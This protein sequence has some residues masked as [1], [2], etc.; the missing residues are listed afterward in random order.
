MKKIFLFFIVYFVNCTAAFACNTNTYYCIDGRLGLGIYYGNLGSYEAWA[1]SIG[2]YGAFNF[3]YY[4]KWFYTSFDI[5]IGFANTAITYNTNNIIH[6]RHE[7]NYSILG[8]FKVGTTLGFL[9]EPTFIYFSL[10]AELYRVGLTGIIN[11]TFSFHGERGAFFNTFVSLGIGAFNRTMI[12]HGFGIESGLEITFDFYTIHAGYG[13]YGNDFFNGG[14][15]YEVSIGMIYKRNYAESLITPT[16][17]NID[18][19]ARLKAIYYNANTMR[20]IH[21]DLGSVEYPKTHDFVILFEMGIY[22][23]NFL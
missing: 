8:K 17:N 23:S 18:F 3:D 14:Q 9:H 13:F 22:L 4:R 20:L 5:N 1:N 7:T 2:G 16:Y 21:R 15:R 19:Y 11:S 6:T 12:A 10:P